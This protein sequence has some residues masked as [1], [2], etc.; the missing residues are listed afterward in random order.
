[1]FVRSPSAPPPARRTRMGGSRSSRHSALAPSAASAAQAHA[2]SFS[3]DAG[4]L[5]E[6]WESKGSWM[7]PL[8]R[9]ARLVGGTLKATGNHTYRF[10]GQICRA[11]ARGKSLQHFSAGHRTTCLRF[12]RSNLP[13]R[14][15]L[16]R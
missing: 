7:D 2:F 13:A 14:R 4:K 12:S 9:K 16:R 15:R 6:S 1:M 5:I 3:F 8:L 11:G 10:E